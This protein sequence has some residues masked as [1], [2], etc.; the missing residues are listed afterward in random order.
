MPNKNADRQKPAYTYIPTGQPAPTFGKSTP[1]FK[2]RV[3][4]GDLIEGVHYC[5]IPG[6][7]SLIERFLAQLPSN[8]A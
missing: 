3:R 1:F 2:A 7:T 6:M 4:S 5:R 8:A